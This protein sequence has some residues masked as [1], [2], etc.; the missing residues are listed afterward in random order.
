MKVGGKVSAPKPITRWKRPWPDDPSQC[1]ELGVVVLEGVV[2]KSG[3]VRGLKLIKGP[4]TELTR[5]ARDAIAQQKFEPAIYRGK[6]V[7]VIYSV[8]INHMPLKK[9]KGP[10]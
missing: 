9:V 1:Y 3:N 6:P 4:N 2:D 10:C 7:D 5:A 8:A